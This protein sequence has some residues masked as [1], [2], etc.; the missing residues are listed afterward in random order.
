MKLNKSTASGTSLMGYMTTDYATLVELFGMP[1]YKGD[2][3]KVTAE[4]V[5]EGEGT[6]FTIYDYKEP[7]TPKRE[8]AWHIGGANKSVLL[9]VREYLCQK[10]K[11]DILV[12][13]YQEYGKRVYGF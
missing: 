8:Y 9:I 12:E 2:G 3:E 5:F 4:W 13:S 11:P 6:V 7:R 10:H 1:H